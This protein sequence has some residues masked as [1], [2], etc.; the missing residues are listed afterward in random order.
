MRLPLLVLA[1]VLAGPRAFPQTPPEDLQK[2]IAALEAE[3]ARLK[4]QGSDAARLDEL[5]RRIDLLAAEIEKA[6]TGG[7]TDV[8]AP[9]KG[10]PGLGPAASKIYRRTSGVSIGG[11]GEV[12][13]GAPSATRQDG[14]PSEAHRRLDL[15][16]YVTYLGYKFSDKILLNSEIEFEHATT[17]EGAEERGEASVEFAYLEFRPWKSAG[18]RAGELLMPLGFL[19]ELHEPPI[20]H[21]A[22]RNEV[23]R[24]IIP[25]TWRDNGVGLFGE[26][27]PFQWRT[28]VVAGLNSAGFESGGIREGRQSG[29][30]SL[31]DDVAFTGRLDFVGAPG[32]LLGGSMFVGNS[33]QRAEIDGRRIRGRVTLFDVHAQY[34]RRG[35]QARALYARSTVGD[36]A[37][38]NA[39]NGL[40]GAESVGSRQY[41]FYAE[42]AYDL[43]TA[44]PHGQWAVVPFARYERLNP[45]D[46]VPAGFEKDPSLDQT[47]WTAGVAVKPLHNVVVKGDYQWA[48]NKARAGVN[49]LNLAVGYLF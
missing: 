39:R 29:S 5:A 38:I 10:E 26:N 21:G 18:F 49:R 4:A 34:E 11:Y 15:L 14:A 32:L 2:R 44:R 30:E 9:T 13:F 7:A 43:M 24:Q 20:F 19:N 28:Y 6:R 45:Q 41:G 12:L 22:R 35:F 23:E 42:A 47:V 40:A 36:A 3:L 8:E 48:S 27:G 46:R 31:A 17:G 25:A 33:G 16:R 37:L 1:L